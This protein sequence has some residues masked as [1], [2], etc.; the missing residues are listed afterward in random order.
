MITFK[1]ETKYDREIDRALKKL[2]DTTIGSEDYDTIL[3]QVSKLHEM[4]Q[5]EKP[6][7]ISPDT[8]LQIAGTLVSIWRIT[9]Y[10]R[11][12]VI[13]STALGFVKKL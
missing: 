4:K 3:E 13:R 1:K 6:N 9:S 10:E 5:E 7:R 12:N 8:M 2:G 11:E